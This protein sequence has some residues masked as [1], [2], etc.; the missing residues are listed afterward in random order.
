MK[1]FW[2]V[3]STGGLESGLWSLWS[4]SS[5]SPTT[6]I[7][8]GELPGLTYGGGDP[9]LASRLSFRSLSWQYLAMSSSLETAP[10]ALEAAEGNV[11][12]K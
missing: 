9:V 7:P 12:V 8:G 11:A 5:P 2:L 6:S 4:P 1:M 10:G 3:R